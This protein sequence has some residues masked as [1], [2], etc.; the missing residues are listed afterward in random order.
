MSFPL[1][2]HNGCYY[3]VIQ[4]GMSFNIVM[5]CHNFSNKFISNEDLNSYE[6]LELN[7]DNFKRLLKALGKDSNMGSVENGYLIYSDQLFSINSWR[8]VVQ[9]IRS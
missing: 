9:I 2:Y 5:E 3:L 6:E 1:Y 4:H 7:S 8:D